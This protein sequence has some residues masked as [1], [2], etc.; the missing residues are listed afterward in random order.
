MAQRRQCHSLARP[1]VSAYCPLGHGRASLISVITESGEEAVSQPG[2]TNLLWP[3]ARV[4]RWRRHSGCTIV[5]QDK[6]PGGGPWRGLLTSSV[7][8]TVTPQ[9][10]WAFL[11]PLLSQA[12]AMTCGSFCHLSRVCHGA[13]F[14]TEMQGMSWLVSR[15]TQ[16]PP[17]VPVLPAHESADIAWNRPTASRCLTIAWERLLQ[18][19]QPRIVVTLSH[20]HKDGF[21]RQGFAG[22]ETVS[23]RQTGKVVAVLVTNSFFFQSFGPKG[24]FKG[25][26]S[27]QPWDGQ[28]PHSSHWG[29]RLGRPGGGQGPLLLP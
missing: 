20:Q 14:A 4:T 24:C 25:W 16:F 28:H 12:G 15:W 19:P 17:P 5:N 27:W 29:R 13:C 23:Q 9:Q 21:P 2:C 1:S 6:H 18:G 8:S 11:G 3:R 7:G 22:P 26:V 10:T